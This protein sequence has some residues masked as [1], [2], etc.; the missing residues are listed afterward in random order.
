MYDSMEMLRMKAVL[1]NLS[2]DKERVLRRLGIVSEA[3]LVRIRRQL[4]R[5]RK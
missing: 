4:E 2:R 1:Q 3:D 5:K